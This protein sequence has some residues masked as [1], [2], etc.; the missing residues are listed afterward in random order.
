MPI[1]V[2]KQLAL[3]A[4][5]SAT[6]PARRRAATIRAAR[7]AEPIR[8]LFYHRVADVIP[9]DWTM[10]TRDFSRQVRWLREH[11]EI[12]SLS[13]AQNRIAAGRN[14]IPTVCITFDDGYADNMQFAVPLLLENNIPFAYFVSTDQVLR[15]KPF[16]HDVAAGRPLPVNT[17]SD[18][19]HLAAAGVE[20]GAHTR[21]HVDIG[22][23]S[24]H[25]QL[26]QEIAGCKQELEKAMG[27]KVPYFAFPYGQHANLSRPAFRLARAAGYV[28][29]CSAYGGYNFPGD[30]SFHLRR[31]H[32]DPEFIRFKNWMTI[33]PRKLRKHCDFDSGECRTEPAAAAL[34][35]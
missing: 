11:C 23:I 26:V 28:G 6:L 18:L 19:C 30:D 27:C 9:N 8:I 17:L 35:T 15:E 7:H 1:S 16:P 24:S 21:G 10:P 32:A 5:Y 4:Y 22:A 14:S 29:V 34:I 33:D 3:G 20:I 2:V 31:I 25:E 12:V 13:E